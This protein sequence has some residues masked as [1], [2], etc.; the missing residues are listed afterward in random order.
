MHIEALP[1]LAEHGRVATALV[2]EARHQVEG[3]AV[4]VESLSAY[5]RRIE[6]AFEAFEVLHADAKATEQLAPEI[7]DAFSD[8]EEAFAELS[9]RI[10]GEITR[11]RSAPTS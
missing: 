1:A 5:H 10:G 2:R 4:T 11:R 6:A 3:P 7:L 8:L 9:I